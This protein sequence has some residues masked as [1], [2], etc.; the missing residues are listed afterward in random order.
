MERTELA[1]GRLEALLADGVET[2]RTAATF[3]RVSVAKVYQLMASGE[4]AYTK[5]GR[6]RRIPRR[7]LI[8]LL[9][10]GLVD[11]GGQ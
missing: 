9:A 2:P 11:R 7:A 8:D 6:C 1:G 3:M 10:Y 4:L 5:I